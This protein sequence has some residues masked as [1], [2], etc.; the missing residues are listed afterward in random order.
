MMLVQL[1]QLPPWSGTL[2]RLNALLQ[3]FPRWGLALAFA[4]ALV[5]LGW[6]AALLVSG[7]LRRALRAV[8]FDEGV[9]R[10]LGHP[11][12]TRP[13]PSGLAAWA[14]HWMLIGAA[15]LLSLEVLGVPLAS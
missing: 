9:N 11:G 15:L 3:D 12:A 13:E 5:L 2:A 1:L 7:V 14:A 8:H 6:G 10:L 4:V